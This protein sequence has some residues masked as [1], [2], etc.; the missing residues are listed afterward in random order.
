MAKEIPDRNLFMMCDELNEEALSKLP[1][2]Y[3]IRN[4]SKPELDY[5]K[6]IH[7]D[8]SQTAHSFGP[9]MTKFFNDV[10][11]PKGDLFFDKCKFVYGNTLTPLATCLIWK[12][13]NSINTI[14]WLKVKKEYEGRGIGRA[15]LS[16]LLLELHEYDFPVYL[17]TQPSSYRAIKLYSDFG[18]NLISNPII[19]RRKNDLFECL[20]ILQEY[21]PKTYY[22]KLNITIAS[23]FF[24]NTV[25][26][27]RSK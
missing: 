23:D 14:H 16:F 6:S 18:F 25:S 26:F 7:F 15:L 20:P 27:F 22:D 10:Y 12:A 2:G 11:A 8:D 21:M 1:H 3:F 9:F 17:H 19:G 13:Y 5:W 24:L 4:C